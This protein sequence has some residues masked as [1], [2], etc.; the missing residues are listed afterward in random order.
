[1]IGSVLWAVAAAYV[2]IL[3]ML[4]LFQRRLVF[5]S[6]RQP[7]GDPAESEAPEM[8]PV[9]YRTADGIALKAW[10]APANDGPTIVYFHG[11]AGTLADRAFKA[12]F[13][14]DR[15]YGMLLTSYRGYSGNPGWPSEEGVYAD[16]RAALDHLASLGVPP[17]S[18]VLYGELLGTGVAVQMALERAAMALIVEAPY[19]SLPDIAAHQYWWTPARWVLRDRF[20]FDGQDRP[21]ENADPD[22]SRRARRHHPDRVRPAPFCGGAGAQGVPWLPPRRA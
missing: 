4:Y 13:L 16:A 15:G 18:T 22:A 21:G 6:A 10:Y 8:R 2:A 11:N 3:A 17:A 1:M 7:I 14:L 19:T 12:R 5:A 9:H 20:D